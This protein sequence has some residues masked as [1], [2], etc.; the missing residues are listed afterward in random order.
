MGNAGWCDKRENYA[1]G[2]TK[3]FAVSTAENV[4]G[5]DKKQSV[6][7]YSITIG[8]SQ[9]LAS[10]EIALVD[11]SS[12]GDTGD[13]RLFR[14]TVASAATTDRPGGVHCDFP[15]GIKF[16]TG[17]IVSGATVTGSVSISYKARY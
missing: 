8:P 3:S 17:L 6:V 13:A 4:M 16:E 10:G 2:W 9:A 1:D 14:Y 11:G 15:R 12:T 5:V 7:V